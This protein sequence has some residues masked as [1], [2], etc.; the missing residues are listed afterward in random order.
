[1]QSELWLRTTT[2]SVQ[3]G[4]DK[5]LKLFWGQLWALDGLITNDKFCWIRPLHLSLSWNEAQRQEA[6]MLSRSRNSLEALEGTVPLEV[7]NEAAM[8]HQT[9]TPSHGRRAE[10]MEP[11]LSTA[12][13]CGNSAK[14]KCRRKRASCSTDPCTAGENR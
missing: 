9:T 7:A 6:A 8:D 4:Q 3:M 14:S 13:A 12:A 11:S 2:S 1:V 5:F 10:T